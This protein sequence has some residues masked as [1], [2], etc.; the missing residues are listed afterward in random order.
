[1][2][3]LNKPSQNAHSWGVNFNCIYSRNTR[4]SILSH[5]TFFTQ[6]TNE[7][8]NLSV[9]LRRGNAAPI[10]G[11]ISIGRGI[12]G[13]DRKRADKRNPLLLWGYQTMARTI[14]TQSPI[15]QWPLFFFF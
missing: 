5:V 10:K 7:K 4:N 11:S 2:N 8:L 13:S 15:V 6:R 3:V 1:M 12:L 9:C 14:P